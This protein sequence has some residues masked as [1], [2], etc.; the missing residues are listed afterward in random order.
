LFRPPLYWPVI[1]LFLLIIPT[2]LMN[3]EELEESYSDR[4]QVNSKLKMT[5]LW[6]IAVCSLVEVDR[7]FRGVYCFHHHSSS[8]SWRQYKHLEHVNFYETAWCNI[9]ED[10]Y[11]HIQCHE[12]VKA[13]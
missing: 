4:G 5:V 2:I 6:N 13:K 10:C 8:W 11:L 3:N 12:N 9:P 1:V 7:R